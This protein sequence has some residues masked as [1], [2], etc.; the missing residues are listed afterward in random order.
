MK[1]LI[2][3]IVLLTLMGLAVWKLGRW[4]QKPIPVTAVRIRRGHVERTGTATSAG[5][6]K[7][8]LEAI[9][10][11]EITGKIKRILKREG[12]Q[13]RKGEPILRIDDR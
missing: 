2:L 1:K 5:T 9:L 4:R 3:L 11:A 8:W 13:V 7:P 10:R 6:V 12:N